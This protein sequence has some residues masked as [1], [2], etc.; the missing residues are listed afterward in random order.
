MNIDAHQ[1]FWY[2]DPEIYGW[3]S[4]EMNILKKDFLPTDLA[5]LLK[6]QKFDGCVAVQA[7]QSLQEN[8]FFIGSC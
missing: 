5:P 4:E 7:N 8:D 6:A 3:I 2:Y 1:H